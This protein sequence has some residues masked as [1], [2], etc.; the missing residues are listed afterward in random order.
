MASE[1]PVD[2]KVGEIHGEYT[3]LG[4]LLA[5]PDHRGVNKVGLIFPHESGHGREI[6]DRF[7]AQFIRFEQFAQRIDTRTV[8]PQSMRGFGYNRFTGH[9]WKGK[10]GED[11]CAPSMM[12]IG[13]T[14]PGHQRAGI[15]DDFNRSLQFRK[16]SPGCL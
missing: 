8:F 6:A 2:P 9:H 1:A 12:L 4:V 16:D 15:E 14:Q 10:V 5:Q 13:R 7:D 3:R 11:L